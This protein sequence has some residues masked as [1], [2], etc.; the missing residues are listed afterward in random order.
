MSVVYNSLLRS[1]HTFVYYTKLIV[2]L[3]IYGRIFVKVACGLVAEVEKVLVVVKVVVVAE[4][5]VGQQSRIV[6]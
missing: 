2:T 1:R 6:I 3:S 4:V 5:V